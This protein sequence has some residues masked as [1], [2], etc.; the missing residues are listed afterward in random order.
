VL[1][2][3]GAYKYGVFGEDESDDFKGEK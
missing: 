1:K 3:S 2:I